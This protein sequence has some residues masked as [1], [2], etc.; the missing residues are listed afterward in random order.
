MVRTGL[1]V[2]CFNMNFFQDNKLIKLSSLHNFIIKEQ[3][4]KNYSTPFYSTILL[5]DRL[6]QTRQFS[7]H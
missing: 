3:M 4:I 7:I 5:S 1:F 6:H 2:Y